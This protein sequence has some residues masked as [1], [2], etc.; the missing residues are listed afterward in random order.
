MIK[1]CRHSGSVFLLQFQTVV[2]HTDIKKEAFIKPPHN[3]VIFKHLYH[4]VSTDIGH[5]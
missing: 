5:E 1:G 2:W 4:R 3:I